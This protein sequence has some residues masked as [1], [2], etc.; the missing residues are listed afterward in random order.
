MAGGILGNSSVPNYVKISAVAI[1]VSTYA[2]ALGVALDTYITHGPDAQLPTIVSLV[3]G[4]GIGFAY[5]VLGL[6]Q[7][8]SLAE[9]SPTGPQAP[10]TT[11]TV[12][13]TNTGADNASAT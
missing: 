12:T 3:L 11:T 7:G 6:H 13:T 8:A 4:T 10:G 2:A 1:L 9:T 5:Q